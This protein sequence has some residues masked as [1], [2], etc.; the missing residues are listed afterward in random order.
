MRTQTRRR[1]EILVGSLEAFFIP[2][3]VLK[4]AEVLMAD[5]PA[6]KGPIEAVLPLVIGTGA[7]AL[8]YRMIL[9]AAAIKD[10]DKTSKA[11]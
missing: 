2:M 3:G 9:R 4:V 7:V 10:D 6:L 8:M 11:E 1:L 5:F